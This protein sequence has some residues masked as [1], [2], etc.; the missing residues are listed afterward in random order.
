MTDPYP[1]LLSEITRLTPSA[2]TARVTAVPD[3]LP[4]LMHPDLHVTACGEV[5]EATSVTVT[6]QRMAFG[7]GLLQATLEIEARR[8]HDPAPEAP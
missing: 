5:W 3:T 1:I 7:S 8:T 2:L 6:G 4:R